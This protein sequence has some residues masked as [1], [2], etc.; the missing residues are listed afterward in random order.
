MSRKSKQSLNKNVLYMDISYMGLLLLL[1]ICVVFIAGYAQ[2]LTFSILT[3]CVIFSI[4][5]ITHFTSVTLGLVINIA[6]I[7][8]TF[9]YFLFQVMS[10]G[11]S[12]PS[13]L[14]FW[15]IIS[16]ILTVLSSS[17]FRRSKEI[18]EENNKM[19]KQLQNYCTVDEET[20]L[21]N[22]QAYEMEMPIYRNIAKR[23][24]IG[25]MLIVW[26]FRYAQDLKQIIG[27]NNLEQTV[28][29]ISREMQNVFRKED[30]VYILSKDS[31]EWGALLLT[32]NGGE[33][34]VKS[35][36]KE[37]LNQIDFSPIIGKNA[38]HLEVQIGMQFKYSEEETPKSM[39]EKAR[40]RLQYDV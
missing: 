33:E 18:E 19:S 25:L 24:N 30:A 7:F 8:V 10:A 27:K 32:Q 3:L 20:Q 21:K 39:L 34:I 6:V 26:K 40:E 29:Q 9:S 31:Y 12:I 13:E 28:A 11:G 36:M 23:Y 5:I 22:R 38:P 4:L 35:R 16:P 15:M 2:N 17:I 14:Y 37:K 1:F